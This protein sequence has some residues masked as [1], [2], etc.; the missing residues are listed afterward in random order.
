MQ[1]ALPVWQQSLA[2]AGF[3]RRSSRSLFSAIIAAIYFQ[4]MSRF[5]TKRGL[6]MVTFFRPERSKEIKKSNG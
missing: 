6:R 2:H 3:F 5:D 4:A 1:A